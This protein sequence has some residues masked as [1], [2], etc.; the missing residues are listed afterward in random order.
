MGEYIWN[1]NNNTYHFKMEDD[2]DKYVVFACAKNEDEYIVEW[3]EHYLQLGFDKIIIADNNDEETLNNI[4][5]KYIEEGIVQIFDVKG[6]HHFQ[7]EIYDMFMHYGNYKWCAYYDVDEFLELIQHSNIKELLDTIEEDT[8]SFN[9]L[10]FG[11]NDEYIKQSN[12][13]Q[14]R[15]KN[16]V[17]PIIQCK[18]NMFIKTI[19][20]GGPKNGYFNHSHYP[21]F[22]ENENY[23]HNICG[24]EVVNVIDKQVF[25]PLRYKIGYIKHYYTKSFE[26]YINK[27]KRGWPDGNDDSALADINHYYMFNS[28]NKPN[29]MS[30][31]QGLFSH[32]G[33]SDFYK[34]VVSKYDVIFLEIPTNNYYALYGGVASIFSCGKGITLIVSENIENSAFVNMLELAYVSENKLLTIKDMNDNNKR[35]EMFINNHKEKSGTYYAIQLF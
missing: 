15:F 33:V 34:D 21:I 4:L 7:C 1:F 3:V 31:S 18:E 20:K 2:T 24:E 25:Y 8:I 35:W 6:L 13:I 17:Y 9:W 22:S 11:S 28:N 26:E 23:K 29:L 10:M 16:P 32:V 14:E 19:I 5:N 27:S 30:I 12:K